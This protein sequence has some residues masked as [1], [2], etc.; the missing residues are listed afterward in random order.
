MA[1]GVEARVPMVDHEFV[2]LA[3]TLPTQLFFKNGMTK[4]VLVEAMG[5]RLPKALRD[6]KTKLGFDTPQARWLRGRLG[7]LL[8]SRVRSCD[9]LEPILDRER[10]A[11]AFREYRDGSQKIPHFFLYRM[12]CLAV[13]LD[14]FRVEPG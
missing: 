3:L 13:W 9:R 4:R 11:R 7:E 14:R 10:A 2:E 1:H 6:R 5:E 12:A 8:E